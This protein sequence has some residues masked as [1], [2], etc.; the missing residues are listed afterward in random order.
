VTS[1]KPNYSGIHYFTC[2]ISPSNPIYPSAQKIIGRRNYM[3]LGGDVSLFFQ[4]LAS[5]AYSVNLGRRLPEDWLQQESNR[6]LV[7]DPDALRRHWVKNEIQDWAS[8]LKDLVKNSEGGI[9]PW[10]L[11]ALPTE[12][13]PYEHKPGVVLIGDAAHLK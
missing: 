9:R 1:S 7:S 13:M 10:P 6:K 12:E 2:R 4:P 11:Y 5:D 8:E 3:A